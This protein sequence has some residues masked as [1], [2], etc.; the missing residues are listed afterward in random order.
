M[1]QQSGWWFCLHICFDVT[2]SCLWISIDLP[3][4]YKYQWLSMVYVG[5]TKS[6]KEIHESSINERMLRSHFFCWS[7][8]HVQTSQANGDWYFLRPANSPVQVTHTCCQN[9]R[10]FTQHKYRN[11]HHIV[12][13]YIN[14]YMYQGVFKFH[15]AVISSKEFK[16]H[17]WS[18]EPRLEW[19]FIPW[20]RIR[21]VSNGWVDEALRWEADL[22]V[23]YIDVFLL[24]KLNICRPH[25][26][27]LS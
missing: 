8:Q 12:L 26:S 4:Y 5:T 20:K 9:N 13:K 14:F 16:G 17:R 15:H 19:S 27:H 23:E 7:T 1:F 24:N 6:D 2:Q 25:C 21:Y 18:V 11:T 22:I 10:C 3:I